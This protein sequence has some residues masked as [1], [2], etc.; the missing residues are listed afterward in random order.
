MADRANYLRATA[1]YTDGEGSG[2]TALGSTA[3][4]ATLGLALSSTSVLV[5]E[6]L[7]ATY[8]FALPAEPSGDVTVSVSSDDT[9]AATVVPGEFTIPSSERDQPR[10]VTVTGVADT[11]TAEITLTA[12][13][14]GYDTVGGAVTVIVYEPATTTGSRSTHGVPAD[15][16]TVV[17][18]SNSGPVSVSSVEFPGGA[19]TGN[20]FQVR[21]D[22]APLNCV[23][24]PSGRTLAGCVQVDLFTLDGNV[25]DEDADG[26][27]FPSATVKIVVT[28]TRGISAH[29][30]ADPSDPWTTIPRCAGEEDTRE[31][32]TVSGNE[33][34]IRNI[35]GFSQFAAAR[36]P[37]A[38]RDR[39]DDDRDDDR[40][41]SVEVPVYLAPVF[42]E[43]VDTTR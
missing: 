5:G 35:Q 36:A 3:N 21:V 6:G 7:A 25:W 41:D 32:F 22:P 37:A 11:A 42:V 40:D 15:I 9:A 33:V 23:T 24:G 29:R 12:A 26:T 8:T 34:T 1:S 39:R 27:A 19:T 31:C 28:S 17:R 16:P 2:K 43:G 38:R 10:T 30:R 13:G 18:P 4:P 14:G 20:P